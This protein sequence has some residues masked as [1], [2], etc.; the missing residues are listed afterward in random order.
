MN[1]VNSINPF[2]LAGAED[3]AFEVVEALGDAPDYHALPVGNAGNI[4]AHWVGYWEAAGM[5]TRALRLLQTCKCTAPQKLA[6]RRP[7][8]LGYQASGAAPIVRGRPVENPE[9]V[10]TAIRIGNPVSWAA[11]GRGERESGGWFAECTDEEILRRAEAARGGRRDF[12]RARVGDR[13]RRRAEGSRA[14]AG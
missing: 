2:R 11:G 13:A 12:L 7:M 1:I 10:A 3:V 14:R 8:M 6:E 5:E 9:T 4:G